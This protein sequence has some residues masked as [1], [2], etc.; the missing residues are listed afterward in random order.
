MFIQNEYSVLTKSEYFS[1]L[2]ECIAQFGFLLANV[3]WSFPQDME[4]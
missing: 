2:D 3:L 1:G 4:P